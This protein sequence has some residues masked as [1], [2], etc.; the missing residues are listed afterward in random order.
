MARGSTR[1]ELGHGARLVAL[2]SHAAL[3]LALPARTA[4][5]AAPTW[6]A[7][8]RSAP[9]RTPFARPWRAWPRPSS[10]DPPSPRRDARPPRPPPSPTG[11]AHG[12]G[13]PR[14][15]ARRALPRLGPSATR[16]PAWRARCSRLRRGAAPAWHACSPCCL[17]RSSMLLAARVRACSSARRDLLVVRGTAPA[18]RVPTRRGSRPAPR[19]GYGARLTW[20][21]AHSPVR[22]IT[23]RT[24]TFICVQ[25]VARRYSS[26]FKSVSTN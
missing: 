5:R 9:A 20:Q 2:V 25:I 23:S 3:P 16:P 15:L 12:L 7:R 22:R 13:S 14:H 21:L 4:R 10:P 11:A 24:F 18:R 8:S 1:S 19:C 6:H 17:A 26:L